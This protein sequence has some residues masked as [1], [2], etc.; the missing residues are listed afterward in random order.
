M[1]ELRVAVY[2]EADELEAV[3]D[4][5]WCEV[6]EMV[7]HLRMVDRDSRFPGRFGCPCGGTVDID[8]DSLPPSA[9]RNG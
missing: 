5:V 1:H 8:W 7:V 2:P 6:L 9:Y 3:V 4:K